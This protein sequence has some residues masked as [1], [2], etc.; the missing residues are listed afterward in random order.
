MC[1]LCQYE[2]PTEDIKRQIKEPCTCNSH[3][4]EDGCNPGPESPGYCTGCGHSL[5]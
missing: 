1:S 5:N 3:D 4:G 2:Y